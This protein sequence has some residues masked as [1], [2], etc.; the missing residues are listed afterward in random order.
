MA[1]TSTTGV[2]QQSSKR[3][4]VVVGFDGSAGAYSALDRATHHAAQVGGVLEIH[5][6]WRR[7]RRSDGSWHAPKE[8][9]SWRHPFSMESPEL[10]GTR[11]VHRYESGLRGRRV[12]DIDGG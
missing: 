6:A 1:T 7:R 12:V 3:P 5:A 4:R 2:E 10:A 8:P 11:T 9:Q